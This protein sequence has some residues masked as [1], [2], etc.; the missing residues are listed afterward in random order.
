MFCNLN[1]VVN[2]DRCLGTITYATLGCTLQV[3][4]NNYICYIG[5]YFTGAWVQLLMPHWV[6]L[7][8]YLRTITYATLGCTLTHKKLKMGQY[9]SHH[10]HSLM[11][12]KKKKSMR[13]TQKWLEISTGARERSL[14]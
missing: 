4:G 1:T 5:L 10:A 14:T 3:P 11:P 13:G 9:S 2:F 7:F 12:C 6:V 8:S